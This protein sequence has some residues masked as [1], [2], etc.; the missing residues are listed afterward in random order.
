MLQI[1]ISIM[2]FAFFMILFFISVII[3]IRILKDNKDDKIILEF[4]T[5]FSLVKYKM[6]IPFLDLAMKKN[7]SPFLKM[8]SEIK[9]GQIDESIDEKKS[10]ISLD[11][12]KKINNKIKRF[13]HSYHNVIQYMLSKIKI[14]DFLWITEFGMK[15]AAITGMISGIF[16][17]VKGYIISILRNN[18]NCNKTTL[19]IVPIFNREVFKTT[20]HC[21][22]KVKIGYII[23][24]GI[25]YGYTFLIKDGECDG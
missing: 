9:K 10:I 19:N 22:I 15:D 17:A 25:K 18:M 24:A 3:D 8:S 7:G 16:W 4:K 20:L 5:L 13:Y 12:M 14:S 2:I 6:E 21:I 23:I 11:E 1:Y